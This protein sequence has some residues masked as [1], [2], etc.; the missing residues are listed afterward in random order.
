MFPINEQDLQDFQGL[1]ELTLG[2]SSAKN[3]PENSIR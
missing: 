2:V 3:C 1:T